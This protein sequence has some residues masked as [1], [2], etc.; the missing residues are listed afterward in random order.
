MFGD[1]F[2]LCGVVV[3]NEYD[4]KIN[5]ICTFNLEK[6]RQILNLDWVR[7]ANKFRV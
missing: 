3:N 5:A 4:L 6:L 2:I 7:F 1:K